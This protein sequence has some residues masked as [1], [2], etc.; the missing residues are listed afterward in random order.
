[1]KFLQIIEEVITIMRISKKK[2]SL[3][4]AL[5]ALLAVMVGVAWAA[6][7]HDFDYSSTAYTVS[8]V[9]GDY[10]FA[11]T[12]DTQLAATDMSLNSAVGNWGYNGDI[13]QTEAFNANVLSVTGTSDISQSNALTFAD[14]PAFLTKKGTGTGILTLSGV[15]TTKTV[16]DYTTF[17]TTV[18]AGTLEVTNAAAI[19]GGT[20][21]VDAGATFNA[22]VT[23]TRVI[24]NSGT[25]NVAGGVTLTPSSTSSGSGSAVVV[26]TGTLAFPAS[27][28]AWAISGAGDV[29]TTGSVTLSGNNS[30]LT[31]SVLPAAASI[32]NAAHVNALGTTLDFG[33]NV[34]TAVYGTAI[35]AAG[36]IPTMFKGTNVAAAVNFSSLSV[37]TVTGNS[38]VFQGKF[39]VN[40]ASVILDGAQIGAAATRAAEVDN[41]TTATGPL[42]L[43][44]GA[45]VYAV[46]TKLGLAEALQLDL[47]SA[48]PVFDTTGFTATATSVIDIVLASETDIPKLDFTV[49]AT[50]FV[51]GIKPLLTVSPG[52]EAVW[53][54]NA[55]R[56]TKSSTTPIPP[57]PTPNV[58]PAT[59]LFNGHNPADMTHFLL[60]GSALT[61][62]KNGTL[63]IKYGSAILGSNSYKITNDRNL[64]LYA[65]FLKSL[66]DGTNTILF[67]SGA[68]QVGKLTITAVNNGG[69]STIDPDGSSSSS[70]CSTGAVASMALLL[71]A[72]LALLRKKD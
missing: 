30:G 51:G 69:G 48:A 24:A 4:L 47:T 64:T 31:G 13:N 66:P 44:D 70:G 53:N 62:S 41:N 71:I 57:T 36:T 26:A 65:S 49:G 54:G 56:I 3:A 6:T 59:A 14:I 17:G 72:P 12:V 19:G 68:T 5:V 63:V 21:T 35:G 15:N 67:M 46:M 23:L 22:G 50:G 29:T 45:K 60:N 8:G 18:A 25:V 2:S 27:S 37:L 11:H 20:V 52:F 33:A 9:P 39:V 7:M 42:V 38:N 28:N 1:M 40:G 55:I 16:G 43:K 61:A 34:A 58:S 32:V 10:P